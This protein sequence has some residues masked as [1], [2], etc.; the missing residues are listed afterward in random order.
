MLYRIGIEGKNFG[1]R[2]FLSWQFYALMQALL[3]IFV[4]MYATQETPVESGK[5]FNF[6]AGGHVVYSECVLAA[7][8][9]IL[10]QTHNYT[11]WNEALIALQFASFFIV[12]YL[13]SV[14]LTQGEIAYFWD[15][16]TSSWTAWVGCFLVGSSIIIEKACMDALQIRKSIVA[17]KLKH[18]QIISMHGDESSRPGGGAGQVELGSVVRKQDDESLIDHR[19]N[20]I[21][22]QDRKQYVQFYDETSDIYAKNGDGGQSRAALVATNTNIDG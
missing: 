1:Y 12:V 19:L 2:V 9:V 4:G 22:G 8:L 11:G 14:T 13:D 5:T 20:M 15:E 16:F 10:R 21:N 3:I 17:Q 7:N 18:S 6:W